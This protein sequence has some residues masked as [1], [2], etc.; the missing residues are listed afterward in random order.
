MNY[1]F[2][3]VTFSIF[4]ALVG[5]S[6]KPKKSRSTGSNH[7]YLSAVAVFARKLEIIWISKLTD[8]RS[9]LVATPFIRTQALLG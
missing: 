7:L 2:E 1:L 9:M 6:T 5:K 8:C 4:V 3:I